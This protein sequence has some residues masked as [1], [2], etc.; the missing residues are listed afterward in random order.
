M[1]IPGDGTSPDNSSDS[2]LEALRQVTSATLRAVAG[3]SE[4]AVSFSPGQASPQEGG[5]LLPLPS[6]PPNPE[7]V[8]RLRGAAD[9]AALRLRFHDEAIHAKYHPVS[10][11]ARQAYDAVEQARIETLGARILPG[12]AR[13]I[14]AAVDLHCRRQSYDRAC[15]CEDV[16]IGEA[17]R[18]IAREC[19]LGISFASA[20]KAVAPWRSRLNEKSMLILGKLSTQLED[21]ETFSRTLLELLPTLGFCLNGESEN[22]QPPAERRQDTQT[23]KNRE[24]DEGRNSLG[25]S[26][27]EDGEASLK[28][29][30]Q[31]TSI[32]GLGK[33]KTDRAV[34]PQ[35]PRHSNCAGGSYAAFTTAFDQ[36]VEADDLC[37][38]DELTHLRAQLDLHL[39]QMQ[40]MIARMA[41]RLQRRLQAQQARS[42]DFDLEEGMLDTGRIAS[43]IINPMHSLTFK[44]E[45]ETAFKDTVVTLLID[46]SGSMR[47]RPI[48]VAAMSADI[49]VR[50]LERC[51]VKVEVLGFTTRDWDGGKSRKKWLSEGGSVHPG[52]LNDLRHIVYKGADIPWRRARRNLGL[53]LQEDILKENIDGEALLWAH[54]R[55]L[56]R[57]E[58]RRILMVISDGAPV[59]DSTQ[60]HNPKSYLE[61]HLREVIELI[62]NKSPVELAAIGIAHDVTRYYRRAVTIVNAEELGGT[63]LR[64]LTDLFSEKNRGRQRRA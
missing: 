14:A 11:V 17:L 59:D 29:E 6:T 26:P 57:P 13:N 4:V 12:V 19:F 46:N 47:G 24:Y 32:Q 31:D 7:D 63:M 56:A 22:M 38:A 23:E 51:G 5:I 21:Q 9:M 8:M 10:L 30:A 18:L 60:E 64:Q 44:E 35:T 27:A 40:G 39:S 58:Q 45:K 20:A 55:L 42:W 41:N 52:R 53:M 16:P 34:H 61:N 54:R 25:N 33:G 36:E 28:T 37:S 48:A 3:R 50:T 43:I 2:R 62:E 1:K 49:L 15:A